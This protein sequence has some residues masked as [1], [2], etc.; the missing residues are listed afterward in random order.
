MKIV[1]KCFSEDQ[2][3][4]SCKNLYSQIGDFEVA[5]KLKKASEFFVQPRSKTY[6]SQLLDLVDE[7]LKKDKVKN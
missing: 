5:Q 3:L 4:E 6:G 7:L 1:N 2:F